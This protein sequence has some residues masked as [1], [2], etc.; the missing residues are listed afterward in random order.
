[1]DEPTE[2][3]A[4]RLYDALGPSSL[5]KDRWTSPDSFSVLGVSGLFLFLGT[6]VGICRVNQQRSHS[7]SSALVPALAEVN[8]EDVETAECE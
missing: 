5:Q 3:D 1:M 2:A 4:T 7:F 6:L 8:T